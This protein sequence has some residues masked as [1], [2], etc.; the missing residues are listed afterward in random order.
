MKRI[1]P[2]ILAML[3]VIG[4]GSSIKYWSYTQGVVPSHINNPKTIPVWIDSRFNKA[5]VIAIND[6]IAEWNGV[7]NGQITVTTVGYFDGSDEGEAKLIKAN[8]TGLG[9]VIMRLDSDDPWLD[10]VVEPGD[11]TLAFVTRFDGHLMV[12]V[13]DM[14]VGRNLKTILMHEMGHLFGAGHVKVANSLMVPY[15]GPKQATCIDKVTVAQVAEFQKMD[16]KSLNYCV[17]PYFE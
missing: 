5:E 16:L 10:G 7:F 3:V 2:F 14:V 17:V 13:G 6:S 15:Y 9:W 4:C 12:V 11:G 8:M 1:L